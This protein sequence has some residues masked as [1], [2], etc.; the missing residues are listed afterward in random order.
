MYLDRDFRVVVL[1]TEDDIKTFLH[2][3]RLELY[4]GNLDFQD[5]DSDYTLRKPIQITIFRTGFP[6]VRFEDGY[7]APFISDGWNLT[8]RDL[9]DL[10]EFC[11]ADHDSYR[12]VQKQSLASAETRLRDLVKW[13]RKE[14]AKTVKRV[15][16][17][18]SKRVKIHH[19]ECD[20]ALAGFE[21]EPT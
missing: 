17:V 5:D 20:E 3:D 4:V 8:E 13:H 19:E 14:L 9:R 1:D 12:N 21:K 2:L 16:G 18:Q 6:E 11:T 7:S 10:T 15:K